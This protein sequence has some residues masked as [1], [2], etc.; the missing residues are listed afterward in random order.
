M[1]VNTEA[2]SMCLEKHDEI[3]PNG[4]QK[5]ITLFLSLY[6]SGWKVSLY[7]TCIN[8]LS[9]K[10]LMRR[11]FTLLVSKHL[12][13]RSLV[14]SRFLQL[15]LQ[16]TSLFCRFHYIQSMK[17]LLFSIEEANWRACTMRARHRGKIDQIEIIFLQVT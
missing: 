3:A 8:S 16:N 15:M 7:F 9:H 4:A 17:R 1:I 5:T 12:A 11:P 13:M 2:M 6:F 10:V 14:F